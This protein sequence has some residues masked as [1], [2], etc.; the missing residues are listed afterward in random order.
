MLSAFRE[1]KHDHKK[2]RYSTTINL[3]ASGIN[4]ALQAQ[5]LMNC[6]YHKLIFWFDG[7]LMDLFLNEIK[8]PK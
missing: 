1:I 5:I 8:N 4:D 7:M 6:F 3:S 2:H